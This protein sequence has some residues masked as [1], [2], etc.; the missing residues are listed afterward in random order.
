MNYNLLLDTEFK[1]L[2]KHW[3]LINCEYQNGYLIANNKVYGIEQ[4]IILL[5]PSKLYFRLEYICVNNSIKKIYC[6][7]QTGDVLEATVEK[8]Q[9]YKRNHIAVV[10]TDKHVEKVKVRFI[11]EAKTKNSEIYVDSPLLLDLTTHDKTWWPK[12]ALNSLLEYQYG[13]DY[14]N[15]YPEGAQFKSSN[16]DFKSAQD[17]SLDTAKVGVIACV[18]KTATVRLN[19]PFSLDRKYL[20]KLDYEE[21]NEYGTIQCRYGHMYS[22]Q[23]NSNLL[24]LTFT[25]YSNRDKLYLEFT[26][27]YQLPYLINLKRILFIDITDLEVDFDD[28]AQLPFT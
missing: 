10:D 11:V 19:V 15:L 17:I 23:L 4:E 13:Y 8:P 26:N 28:V 1:K 7:I 2:G 5:Q 20:L 18:E 21:L 12:F 6:G 3:K 14:E 25:H 22:K 24:Y 9:L 27:D 16:K